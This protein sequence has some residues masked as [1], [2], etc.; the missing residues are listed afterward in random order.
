MSKLLVVFGLSAVISVGG[1][2]SR[3]ATVRAV[4][5]PPGGA[6]VVSEAQPPE[7]QLVSV[8]RR[9]AAQGG[10]GVFRE[11][12][13]GALV[14]DVPEALAST[15]QVGS[16]SGLGI[17][18]FVRL[19]PFT[20][21][22]VDIALSRLWK[23]VSALGAGHGSA[24]FFFDPASARIYVSATLGRAVVESAAGDKAHLVDY[25][26]G[27]L[28]LASRCADTAPFWGGAALEACSPNAHCTTSFTVIVTSNGNRDL[29]TAGHCY[30]NIQQPRTPTGTVVGTVLNRH[31]SGQT[32]AELI[33]GAT[34]GHYV[35]AG[36]AT[37]SGIPVTGAGDPAVSSTVYVSGA[38]SFEHQVVVVST[39]VSGTDDECGSFTNMFAFRVSGGNCPIIPG[40][41][42][43]PVYSKSGGSATARGIAKGI[44]TDGS[45]CIATKWS[46]VASG[47]GVTIATN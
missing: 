21:R 7:Q 26:D 20:Q 28:R 8:E 47:L 41:S 5:E 3:P 14:V 1:P 23:L 6:Q 2:F 19:V 9:W 33:Y 17:P 45:V 22:D 11:A 31:C 35:Y 46:S 13:S 10:V 24:I 29:T 36:G 40:D 4:I 30:L 44:S 16:T 15:F 37:G 32:D 25:H 12:R 42:G 43:G 38:Q 39:A 27:G 18:V 34:Y